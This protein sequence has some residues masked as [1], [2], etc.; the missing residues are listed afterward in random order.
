MGSLLYTICQNRNKR[1]RV[2]DYKYM[3]RKGPE[4]GKGMLDLVEDLRLVVVSH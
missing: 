1:H 4:V 3:S 2:T